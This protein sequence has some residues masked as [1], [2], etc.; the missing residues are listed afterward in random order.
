MC[1]D[2]P[3][4]GTR[5]VR[6]FSQCDQEKLV[7]DLQNAPWG[8]VNDCV[9]IDGKWE[10][11]KKIFFDV[12]NKHVPVRKVRP[13][14]FTLPWIDAEIH[15]LMRARSYHLSKAQRSKKQEDWVKYKALRN[16]VTASIRKARADYFR[17][18]THNTTNPRQVWKDLSLII[19][20]SKH[21]RIGTI[22][23]DGRDITEDCDK[24]ELFNKFFASCVSRDE[25]MEDVFP[26]VFPPHPVN[27]TFTFQE[28]GVE[29]VSYVLSTL[30]VSKSTGVDRISPRMLR[31]A[32]PAIARSLTSIFN[33][34]LETGV[35]PAEWK[36]AYITAVHKKD[37]KTEVSNYR[38]VSILPVV[39]KVF[40]NVIHIQLYSYMQQKGF[41]HPA[42]SGFRPGHNT[43][44]VLERR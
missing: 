41:L 7:E 39:A 42:Q 25:Q 29:E 23:K 40:E 38:P 32:A 28:I 4:C 5:I 31:L 10:C 26:P 35:V 12:L 15:K 3:Q 36:Q 34:S 11:W 2:S 1:A 20:R 6:C 37:A 44:D 33:A 16:A 24:A 14:A 22:C 18:L 43:Q 27:H 17:E 8:W 21:K 30:Q 19:G 13:R 9:S